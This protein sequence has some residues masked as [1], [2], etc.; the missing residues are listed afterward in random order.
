MTLLFRATVCGNLNPA[1][2][3]GRDC[4]AEVSSAGTAGEIVFSDEP[5]PR[6]FSRVSREAAP[7]LDLHLIAQGRARPKTKG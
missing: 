5:A 6:N 1:G 2:S 3:W 4:M 7:V